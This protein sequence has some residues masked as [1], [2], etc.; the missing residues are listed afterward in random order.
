MPNRHW[1]FRHALIA[2]ALAAC[3]AAAPS[4]LP[5]EQGPGPDLLRVELVATGGEVA[6]S[7]V[8][9]DGETRVYL[10]PSG[11]R[12]LLHAIPPAPRTSPA[13]AARSEGTRVIEESVRSTERWETASASL[14]RQEPGTVLWLPGPDGEM[15]RVTLTSTVER[16]SDAPEA[17]A[18]TET[19]SA[20]VTL[21]P[22]LYFDRDGDGTLG[23][24]VIGIYPNER[25]SGVP[26][27]VARNP[28][29]YAPPT[30]FFRLDETTSNLP[31]ARR[32]RFGDFHPEVFSGDGPRY[33]AHDPRLADFWDAL[34][35]EVSDAGRN[36]SSLR[37]LRGYV[38]PQERLRLERMGIQLAEFSRYQYGDALAII[39]DN[40]QNHRMDDLNGDG[41]VDREDAAVLAEWVENA[42][43][44]AGLAGG[45]GVASSFE[46]PNH[47]G[48]PYV[49][50]DLRGWFD[51]WRE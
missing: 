21:L 44:T 2:A 4:A 38:S 15:G 18:R 47:I 19:R 35:E 45:I 30:S 24:T 5:A 34:A 22:A 7:E 20:T 1:G 14:H 25:A 6:R 37:I 49:H 23:G 36:W 29:S 3:G 50:A 26:G 39:Y 16:E 27:P 17:E 10:L 48:T 9:P 8:V 32:A 43:R 40:N 11:T 51:R 46:G 12:A 41:V 31:V 33:V 13:P 28:R 42:M